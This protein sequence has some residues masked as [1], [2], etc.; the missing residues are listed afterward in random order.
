MEEEK[1]KYEKGIE[2]LKFDLNK[3]KI[4]Y[5]KNILIYKEEKEKLIKEKYN[6]E[7]EIKKYKEIINNDKINKNKE[8]NEIDKMKKDINK[9]NNELEERE[10]EIEKLKKEL[11][12]KEQI[13]NVEINTSI[14]KS[15]TEEMK[16]KDNEI[17]K[18]NELIINNLNNF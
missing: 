15:I 10:L 7:I 17:Q 11:E 8:Q 5:D 14:N 13:K 12:I 16:D 6:L 4:E 18:Q 2:Y 9:L 1:N 3:N